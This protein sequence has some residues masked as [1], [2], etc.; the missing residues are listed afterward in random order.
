MIAV[1]GWAPT[2]TRT[3]KETSTPVNGTRIAN[4]DLGLT[5][6]PTEMNI[7]ANGEITN[8]MVKVFI[9]T[10]VQAETITLDSGLDIGKIIESTD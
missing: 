5:S 9:N 2:F 4:T 8:A 7:L 6:G 10:T 3:P 1:T